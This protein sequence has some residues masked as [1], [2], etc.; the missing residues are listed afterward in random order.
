MKTVLLAIALFTFSSSFS[1]SKTDDTIEQYCR[2]SLS[3]KLF[4]DRIQIEADFG[5]KK[6]DRDKK[7]RDGLKKV[8]TFETEV[9]ALNYMGKDGWKLV[10]VQ[11]VPSKIGSASTYYLF[12]KDVT[13]LEA[14]G[15]E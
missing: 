5:E 12:K 13:H 8:M 1:Q 2:I 4:S 9:D 7:L 11:V 3:E 6:R 15:E 10:H 14:L